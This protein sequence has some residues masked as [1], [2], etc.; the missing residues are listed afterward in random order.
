MHLHTCRA[1]IHVT[2]IVTAAVH[3]DYSVNESPWDC[4]ALLVYK[5]QTF[6]DIHIPA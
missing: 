1:A 3:L 4:A 6:I 2:V 5:L